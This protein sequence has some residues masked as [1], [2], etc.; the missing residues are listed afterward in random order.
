MPGLYAGH[1]IFSI[2]CINLPVFKSKTMKLPEREY[3][4]ISANSTAYCLLSYLIIFLIF[5]VVTA[6][7]SGL[8]NIPV[9]LYYNHVG[10]NCKS[11]IWTTDSVK[12]VFGSGNAIL[13]ILAI[14][15]LVIYIKAIE[16]NG[17]LRMFFL[18]GFIH[19][20]SM[21]IGSAVVGAFIFEG[22]GFVL[23][24]LYI[25]E[26]I[27]MVILFIGIFIM[28]IIGLAM[29]KPFLFSSN[30][31]YNYL[32][33]EMRPIFRFHQFVVPYIV[34]TLIIIVF[35]FPLSLYEML[36]LLLP[37]FMLIP[38]FLS[39]N[40]FPKFYFEKTRKTFYY[41]KRLIYITIVVFVIYRVV[42]GIGIDF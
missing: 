32:S 42:L 7:T 5:Q 24:Y 35:K 11:D 25:S 3:L 38:L 4:I 19:A 27:K 14:T 37:V 40:R 30:I 12:V 31:Y 16:F 9:T 15:F 39:I 18:W 22:F 33:P 29:L 28:L 13:I 23:T 34:S 41:D 10:F 36:L 8:F 17:L 20:T 1:Y 26:T 21:V 2:K 6:V